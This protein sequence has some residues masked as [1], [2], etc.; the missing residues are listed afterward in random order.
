M[1]VATEQEIRRAPRV[2]LAIPAKLEYKVNA[3]TSYDEVIRLNDVSPFGAG[4]VID[5]PIKRG[6][7]IHLTIPMPRQLR[8]YDHVEPQYKIWAIVRHCIPMQERDKETY[9]IGT[10][11]IGKVPPDS[12]ATDPCR[13]YDVSDTSGNGFYGI[14]DAPAK[15]DEASLPKELRRHS[16]YQIPVSV[17]LETLNEKGEVLK[18]EPSVT[19]NVSL[20]GASVFTSL[21]TSVGSF[22]RFTSEQNN[23]SIISVVRGKR[24]GQDGFP[25][26]H[27]EFV[28]R[29]FPLDGVE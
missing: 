19:E 13:I 8:S 4:F 17:V 23:L 21:Q 9:A 3:E 7:L 20:G 18:K 12:Y 25:R 1:S 11:F 2:G 22:L 6:R 14:S 27:I 29:Y 16:R 10:A 24:I 15:P 26:L 28:D 5:H